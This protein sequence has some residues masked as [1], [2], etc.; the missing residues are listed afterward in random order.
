MQVP[1]NCIRWHFIVLAQQQLWLGE[2]PRSVSRLARSGGSS[3]LPAVGFHALLG[4][5]VLG[6]E[7][8]D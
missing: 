3:S 6:T 2:A 4:L 7:L 8:L 1:L 5:L